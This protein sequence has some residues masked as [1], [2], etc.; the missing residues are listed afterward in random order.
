VLNATRKAKL[1]RTNTKDLSLI[2]AF[3]TGA[4]M[5]RRLGGRRWR[6][7]LKLIT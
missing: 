6:L 7:L 4:S 5:F 3:I 1:T 2:R